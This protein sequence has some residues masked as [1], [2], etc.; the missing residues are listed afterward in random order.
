MLLKEVIIMGT[1]AVGKKVAKVDVIDKVLGKAIFAPDYYLDD[2]LYIKAFRAPHPHALIKEVDISKAEE[3][4]GVELIVTAKELA[5]LNNFGL[6][7]KD[8][9]ILAREKTRSM[10]DAI[11]LI[12]ATSEEVARRAERLIEVA[13]EELE[14]IEEPL[15]AME[16]DAPLI[17]Q[18]GNIL[19]SHNLKKGDIKQGFAEADLILTNEF[20]TQRIEQLPLQ[21][22]AGVAEYDPET[23]VYTIWAATQWLH[24][25]QIDVAHALGVSPSKINIVQPIIGGA[26]GKREDVSVQIHLALMAKLTGKKVKQVYTRAESMI[27]QSKRHPMIIR[28]KS[29]VTYAGKI[30][31]WEVEVIGD[32][33]AYASSGPAVVHQA[34]YHSTGPYNI[35]NIAG[36]SYTVYTNN[37]YSGAMR[38]FGATQA[39]FAY[40]S[41]IDILAKEIG[42]DPVEFRLKNG[43]QRGSITP[44]GQELTSSVGLKETIEQAVEASNYQQIKVERGNK[45][46][47]VGIASIMFGNGYG[48]GYP[49]HST[50]QIKVEDDGTL[51]I[52]TAAAD[53]GQGV[54]T[55]V[56][57]I[58]SEV[59]NYPIEGMN[60]LQGNT[61][62]M[63]N[64]GS[65]SATRQTLFTGNATK[66]AAENMLAQIHHHAF[67][68]LGAHYPSLEIKD[69]KII[70]K[71]E[72]RGLTFGKLAR[73]AKAKGQPLI[74]EGSY[75]PKTDV[76]DKETGF[77]A[78]NYLA[79]TFNTQIAEVVVDTETGQ[80]EVERIVAAVDIGK[81]IHPQNIE[82][83]SEGGTAMG[84]GM[85]LME[86]QII[87]K[88][89]T[90]NPNLSNYLVPTSLDM[91]EIE[92]IIVES[93]DAVGPYGA[94]GIGEPA[95]IPTAPAIINAIEDAIGVRIK[96][97]PATPE[98]ILKAVKSKE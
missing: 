50:C 37:T 71:G 57:Q 91:P 7:I 44:N 79:Y 65:T 35:D 34:L 60:F 82:G 4:A 8:Q 93:K 22:E 74:A 89:I 19:C 32:T 88:G 2:M 77:S 40:E 48:E 11:A 39:A 43:Y 56:A 36:K 58:I 51:T 67:L 62:T 73:L 31:A 26:F 61:A 16:D 1:R 76:P 6:I 24:D 28:I 10:G 25:T 66:N 81:A 63:K 21:T 47:G 54:L 92:T 59:L 15:R 45:K 70:V 95:M 69:G 85:A 49:D 53:V 5:E 41:Q 97:L 20:R 23:E 87:E 75:F 46:R 72:D 90:K 17:H 30:T 42:M 94:K 83:Q 68:E 64:A 12:A 52:K 29:G 13:Y 18:G 98:K 3:L 14:V 9:E 78:K 80:V 38:G 86:D 55:L 96:E 33:G 27:A 84:L